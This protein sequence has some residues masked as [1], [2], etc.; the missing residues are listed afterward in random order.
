MKLT[1]VTKSMVAT[2]A[3]LLLASCGGGGGGSDSNQ[4]S[5]QL[6][7]TAATGAA[8][9]GADVQ[10]KCAGGGTGTATTT[11]AGGYTV[12]ISGGT[13][14]CII[15]V[16]GTSNGV[17]VSLHSVADA[18]TAAANGNVNATANVTPVTEMIVAQLLAAMPSDAFAN[19]NPQQV[20]AA[21]V[22]S[23]ATAIID[24]LKAAGVDLS[25]ID[26]LKATLVPATSTTAGN[27]YDQLLD[28]LGDSV[29]PEALPLV[30]NQ[31]ATAAVTSSTAGLTNALVAVSGGSLA[32]CPVA[33]SGRYRT[34]EYYGRTAVREINFKDMKFQLRD[35]SYIDMTADAAQPCTFTATGPDGTGK[36]TEWSVAF[37]PS[38][39]GSFRAR[40]T[41]PTATPGTVG[42]IFPE[43]AHPASTVV[44]TWSFLQSG[45]DVMDGQIHWAG[46]LMF[47]SDNTV[48][49]CDYDTSNWSCVDDGMSMTLAA[50][51]DGG[52]DLAEGAEA[53]AQMYAY[54]SPAGN[55]ALFGTT[56][57]AG[58][59]AAEQ[60]TILVAAKLEREALPAVGTVAKYWDTT[61]ERPVG[62]AVTTIAPRADQ[63]TATAVDTAAGTVTRTRESDGRVDVVTFNS[64]VDGLRSRPAFL[65]V[66]Q[67][68]LPGMGVT[69]IFNSNPAGTHFYGVTPRR[70]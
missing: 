38:G 36:T 50:R 13:L 48:G 66:Y 6:S 35:G 31:I 64:P 49:A 32:G 53:V 25:G 56:N 52:F 19:F 27:G 16:S 69:A 58:D 67:M 70:P 11:T 17:A 44:G 54:R 22:S 7:G 37:G 33:I 63:T 30:V 46:K 61:L 39:V 40:Y 42:Y 14:P 28:L 5:L 23:A 57:A 34:L 47:R 4:A 26:P 3:G 62:G 1:L 43:Q 12:S 18:G 60:Q 10:V 45:Y 55:V 59:P 65:P 9:A 51:T 24:A 68:P 20:T 8:L 21:A 41:A 29:G 2:A 15:K